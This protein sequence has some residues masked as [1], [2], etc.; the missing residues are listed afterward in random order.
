[1]N[2]FERMMGRVVEHAALATP[3]VGKVE[4]RVR[5]RRRRRVAVSAAGTFTLLAAMGAVAIHA[6]AGPALTAGA[7]SAGRSP[8]AGTTPG[9]T[10]PGSTR[11]PYP[12]TVPAPPPEPIGDRAV[13]EVRVEPGA[14]DPFTP[15]QV[16]LVN[17]T[18]APFRSCALSFERWLGDG[19]GD[20]RSLAFSFD[21][22]GV[23]SLVDFGPRDSYGPSGHY[24]NRPEYLTD[25]LSAPAGGTTQRTVPFHSDPGNSDHAREAE[26]LLPGTYRIVKFRPE[27]P[28]VTGRFTVTP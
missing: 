23:T 4:G 16:V 9:G 28:E 14:A 18:G 26:S 19:W 11:P 7:G 20:Y 12:V 21:N 8:G 22:P 10:T 15:R 13:V 5:H 1:M 27:D 3:V 17:H 2:E 24:C 6:P 25:E